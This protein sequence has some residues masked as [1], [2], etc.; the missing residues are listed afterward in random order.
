MG[1]WLGGGGPWVGTVFGHH[2]KRDNKKRQNRSQSNTRTLVNKEVVC[3]WASVLTVEHK[4]V[5]LSPN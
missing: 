3:V 2:L 1:G 4:T 5:E